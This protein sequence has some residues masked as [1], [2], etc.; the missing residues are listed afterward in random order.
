MSSVCGWWSLL[1]PSA[2]HPCLIHDPR[3]TRASRSCRLAGNRRGIH[4]QEAVCWLQF[5]LFPTFVCQI[6][7]VQRRRETILQGLRGA[8]GSRGYTLG[9]HDV[10]GMETRQCFRRA[11][12]TS[13]PSKHQGMPWMCGAT[14]VSQMRPSKGRRRIHTW[15]VGLFTQDL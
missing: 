9:M 11:Q 4:A 13:E 7:M 12:A 5:C 10:Q 1:V 2:A 15:G 6:S 14:L 8:Q 3:T